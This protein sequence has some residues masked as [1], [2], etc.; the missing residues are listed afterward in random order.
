MRQNCKQVG[1]RGTSEC[2]GAPLDAAFLLMLAGF[3]VKG[4]VLSAILLHMIPLLSVLGLGRRVIMVAALFGPSHVAS[5]LISMVFGGRLPQ[6]LLAVVAASL[7][8]V[9]LFVLVD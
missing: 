6:T 5:R 4:F 7:L 3:A 1:L 9:G 8:A 2:S